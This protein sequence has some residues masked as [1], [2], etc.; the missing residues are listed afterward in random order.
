MPT[1]TWRVPR[2]SVHDDSVL[3]ADVTARFSFSAS[4]DYIL[5][6]DLA[7]VSAER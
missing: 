3:Q 7:A 4:L 5:V 6:T 2:S 1:T